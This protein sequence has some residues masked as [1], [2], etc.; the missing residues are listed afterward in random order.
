MRGLFTTLAFG[1]LPLTLARDGWT[2]HKL[3]LDKYPYARCLDGSA[4]AYY[5]LPGDST[6]VLHLQG[7]GWCSSLADCAARARFPVY[8]G[9]ASIG[10]TAAW[11]DPAGAPCTQALRSTTPPCESDGG[12]G[13]ILSSNATLNPLF[14]SATKVWLGYCS[15][16]GFSGTIQ[17]PVAVNASSAVHFGGSFILEAILSELFAQHGMAAA[18]SVLLKG[19]SAGGASTFTH[20]DFVGARVRAGTGGAARYAALPGAGFLLD[21]PPFNNQPN[22]YTPMNQWVYETMGANASGNAACIAAFEARE[23]G[24]GWHCFMPQYSLPYIESQLFVANSAADAAQMGVI[25]KLGCSP[26]AGTCSAAQLAYLDAFHVRFLRARRSKNA[27]QPLAHASHPLL[28]SC[29]AGRHGPLACARAVHGEEWRI[30]CGVRRA[31]GGERGQNV[32]W[33]HSGQLDHGAGA[34]QL[35]APHWRRSDGN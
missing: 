33:H 32:Q 35:V 16:D 6:Y 31:Y 17:G 24:S 19:C 27:R 2:L 7:G 13:G 11:G 3:P 21:Y 26:S 15:G 18:R 23:A 1:G 4:G 30:P 12:S 25:M 29:P 8:S 5:T 28:I 14:A 34:Q 20:A 9:E 10:S 22:T